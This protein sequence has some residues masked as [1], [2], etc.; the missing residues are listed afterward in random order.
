MNNTNSTAV[1]A[2]KAAKYFGIGIEG[3]LCILAFISLILVIVF[4]NQEPIKGRRIVAFV[5]T[6]LFFLEQI[7]RCSFVWVEETPFQFIRATIGLILLC[8]FQLDLL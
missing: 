1:D 5:T 4:R 2:L 8:K 7:E 3:I 6:L